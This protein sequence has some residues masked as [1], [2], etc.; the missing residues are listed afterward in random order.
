MERYLM[1]EL[2]KWKNE[3]GRKPLIIR[4]A[5]QV[6][7]TWIMKEF[8]RTSF[9]D[10][11]YINFEQN[12]HIHTLFDGDL[13][14]K[15][16]LTGLNAETGKTA[17]GDV[18]IIFD[19]IQEC[20]RALTALKY[21][22]EEAPEYPVVAAGSNLG[23]A[24]H[25]GTS[26]PV[27]KTDLLTLF[28]MSFREFLCAVGQN[29]LAQVIEQQDQGMIRA[30]REKYIDF[31]RQYY[32][33]GGMPEVVQTFVDTSDYQAARRKQELLL[34]YYRLDFSKH[35]EPLL[36]ERLNQVWDSI[37]MQLSKENKKFIFGQ[38]RKGA[39]S[40]DFE[41]AIKWL[42]DCGLIYTVHRVNKPYIPLKS[43]EELSIFKIYLLDTGLLGA[44]GG[45]SSKTILSGSDIFTEFKG[46]MTEQYVL[47]QMMAVLG[48]A[49]YYYSAENARM[50]IDFLVQ[51][52]ADVIPIEVKA[53]ENLRARSLRSFHEKYNP[54][55][56]VRFSMSDFREQDWMVNVP[57]YEVEWMKQVVPM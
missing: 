5:R 25:S 37:P 53:E 23:V 47:A 33:V 43:Y 1:Q 16:L 11:I 30:F 24:F 6:G 38:I 39:R 56:S 35:A 21:F 28:P 17:A 45:I 10:V 8:G 9:R 14:P 50:E 48:K 44:M 42:E 27:G 36:T 52:E 41:L 51:G 12:Q 49:P 29:G 46:A 4:G 19:E 3:P 55:L 18:L 54:A 40:K 22:C 7:K 2:L 20:P 32:Y 31:L 15:R 26:Y 34:D 13:S 57:L